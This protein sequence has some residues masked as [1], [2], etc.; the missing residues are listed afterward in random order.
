[1]RYGRVTDIQDALSRVTHF[2]WCACG[3]LASLTDP[4]GRVTTW[5]R[6]LQGRVGDEDLSGQHADDLHL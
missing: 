5:T 6:D 2:E 3:S 1:M 4:L